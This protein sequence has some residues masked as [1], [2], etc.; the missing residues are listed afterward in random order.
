MS[1]TKKIATAVVSIVLASSMCI[2]LTACGDDGNK[3]NYPSFTPDKPANAS[4]DMLAL[5]ISEDSVDEE[6]NPKDDVTLAYNTGTALSM[7]VGY[8]NSGRYGY[9]TYQNADGLVSGEFDLFGTRYAAGRLKPAWQALSTELGI[10][11]ADNFQNLSSD[12]QVSQAITDGNL[13]TYNVITASANIITTNANSD[14]DLFLDLSLYLD[15]MPNYKAFLEENPLVMLSLTSNVDSGAMYYAPY[16]DGNDDIEKYEL[17]NMNWIE[18]LLDGTG[19][20]DSTTFTA[21]AKAKQSNAEGSTSVSSQGDVSDGTQAKA[22]SYMGKTGN[23]WV[24]VTDVDNSDLNADGTLKDTADTSKTIKVY[25]DYDNVLAE[26]GNTN[27]DLYKAVAAAGVTDPTSLESGNIVDI[28]NAAINA[29]KGEVTG[30]QLLAILRNYIDVAYLDADGGDSFY[31]TRSDVF[32]GYNAAWDVDLLVALSRCV[33]TNNSLLG[34]DTAMADV[35]ALSGRQGTTQ[36]MNDLLS[37]TGELYGERGLTFRYEYAYVDSDNTIKDARLNESTYDALD[38]M[39]ALVEEGLIYTGTATGNGTISYYTKG[40][41]EALMIFDYVQTQT[42]NGG[43]TAMGVSEK[44][45]GAVDENYNFA[46]I[47]TPVS[48]WSDGTTEA[49]DGED[50]DFTA[51]GEKIMRFTESWRSVKN[52]GFCVPYESVKDKPEVLSAVLTFIDYLFSNDG[53]IL[54]TYGPQSTNNDCKETSDGVYTSEADGFWYDEKATG[55]TLAD[56]AV[57]VAGSEQYTV[58]DEYAGQYFVYKNEVY[59]GTY[60]KGEMQPTMTDAN[61]NLY[62]GYTVNE[63]KL[64]SAPIGSNYALNYTSYARGVIGSALPIGNKL[65]SFEYQCTADCGIIGA[66]KVAAC[67]TNGTISHVYLQVDNPKDNP[68]YTIIP[69]TLPYDQATSAAINTNYSGYNQNWFRSSSSAPMINFLLEVMFRGLDGESSESNYLG[70]GG[71][72]LP[73]S[74]ADAVEMVE[75]LGWRTYLG[76]MQDA[77]AELLEYYNG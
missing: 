72:T 50:Y 9:I 57:Q 68:W 26:L 75:G 53:Q 40:E 63:L 6:G 58:K 54:M 39:N 42:A 19:A 46:P 51:D 15:Y 69:T 11:F 14:P 61:L 36:R 60:Y 65:Q 41:I 66:D 34:T 74:A 70:T 29:K 23:W 45:K 25:V 3:I 67:L 37:L 64:G 10:S 24:E 13:A 44:A 43:Y 31:A 17:A 8:Q 7:N 77:W 27:S 32:N 76:Y 48:K 62:Y 38:K 73:D 49:T 59:T 35:Y 2:G 16:F 22:E 1:K 56:V 12:A 52:T 21:Q 20:G 71:G 18:S 55:V 28:Q 4:Q 5:S 33:V 30:A 47:L